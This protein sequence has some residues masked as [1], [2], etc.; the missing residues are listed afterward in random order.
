MQFDAIL[1][2]CD[3]VLVDS[4]PLTHGVLVQML[5]EAG[6]HLTLEQC[7]ARFLGKAVRD[8][9]A[10][11]EAH[12][13]RP[14]TEAWMAAF[15]ARR[16][17]ALHQHLQPIAGAALAVATLHQ[18]LH[19][20]I[21]CVSGADRAKVELQLA[22]VDLLGFFDGRIFSGQEMPRT[23]PAPDVYLAAAAAL[24]VAPARCAVVED[25]VTGARAG[26]DAGA[27]VFGYAPGGPGHSSAEAL[28]TLGVAQVFTDM[29][30]LPALLG[31]GRRL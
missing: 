16:N 15:Y 25:S 28:R 3:G 12:T 13:G 23:K 22:K 27:V 11:I 21:A 20:Q 10:A 2:D 7:M 30:E 19:G 18:R 9:R 24:G 1:F 26:L 5:G 6:W 17:Q 14:L 29:A 8:E 4:E 31:A